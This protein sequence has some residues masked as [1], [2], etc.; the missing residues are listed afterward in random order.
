MATATIKL[1]FRVGH[2]IE[3]SF[4]EAIRIASILNVFCEFEFNGV[5]CLAHANSSVEN[6][7]KSYHNEITKEY[8]SKLAVA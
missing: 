1:E 2:N 5:T 7:V 3:E 6:G 4:K 8:G